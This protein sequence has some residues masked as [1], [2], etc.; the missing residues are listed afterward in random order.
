MWGLADRSNVVYFDCWNEVDVTIALL[1]G[2]ATTIV[3]LCDTGSTG[4]STRNI[5]AELRRGRADPRAQQTMQDVEERRRHASLDAEADDRGDP[6]VEFRG[7]AGLEV[8]LQR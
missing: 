5:G 7:A 8:A 3:E 2:G 4:S 6:R 1:E